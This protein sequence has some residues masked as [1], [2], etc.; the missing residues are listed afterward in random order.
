MIEKSKLL[1]NM[2]KPLTQSLFLEVGYTDYA[3]YTW[4]DRDYE[5]KGRLYPSLRRLYIEME[6]PTEYEFANTHLLNWKQWQRLCENKLI[7]KEIDEWR[8]ELELRLRSKGIKHIISNAKQGGYQ[9]AKWLADKGW[10][11]RSAGRPSK[12][13]IEREK[14]FQSRVSEEFS[15]DI[16]RLNVN[17]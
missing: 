3:V 17:A 9:S 7:R 2:G 14:K 5:Y 6:D 4:K 12:E 11:L 15:A 8:E 16:I 10:D 1:D 13:E